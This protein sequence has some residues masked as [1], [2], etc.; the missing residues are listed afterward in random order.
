MSNNN[1]AMKD[2]REKSLK[3][4]KQINPK[5]NHDPLQNSIQTLLV[6][7]KTLTNYIEQLRQISMLVRKQCISLLEM[8]MTP[9]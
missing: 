8:C 9:K 7:E 6:N 5:P 2:D 1:V 4:F 3:L